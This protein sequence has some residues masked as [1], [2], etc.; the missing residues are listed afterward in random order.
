MKT[1]TEMVRLNK[2]AVTEKEFYDG[3]YGNCCCET[4]GYWREIAAFIIATSKPGD[5]LLDVGCGHGDSTKLLLGFGC[6]CVGV[7]ISLKGLN[8]NTKLGDD[9]NQFVGS[10]TF[11]EA[12]LWNMPFED[13]QFD[14]TFSFDVMEHLITGAVSPSIRE[15]YRVTKRRTFHCIS[16]VPSTSTIG[17]HKTVRPISWWRKRFVELNKKNIDHYVC[18]HKE[19]LALHSLLPGKFAIIDNKRIWVGKEETVI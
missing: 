4:T 17:M 8:S 7:D 3:L 11:V 1:D 13:N 15:I 10:N 12:P 16:E 18:S 14:Y 2:D 9:H 6:D 5:K 19:F